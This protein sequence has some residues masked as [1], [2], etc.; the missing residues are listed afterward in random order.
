MIDCASRHEGESIYTAIALVSVGSTLTNMDPVVR[1]VPAESLL[2]GWA[3]RVRAHT[4]LTAHPLNVVARNSGDLTDRLNALP[5]D[6]AGLIAVGT[7]AAHYASISR[8]AWA[9]RQCAVVTDQAMTAVAAAAELLNALI[10]H[11]LPPRQSRVVIAGTATTPLLRRLLMAAGI[12]EVTSWDRRDAVSFPLHLVIRDAEAVIDLLGCPQE[13]AGVV[14]EHPNFIVIGRDDE[15]RLARSLLIILHRMVKEPKPALNI[16]DYYSWALA[17]VA[18]AVSDQP[19]PRATETAVP[20]DGEVAGLHVLGLHANGP[21]LDDLATSRREHPP[22]RHARGGIAW[23]Q[24]ALR[25]TVSRYSVTTNAL[26]AGNRQ[27]R[28][29]STPSLKRER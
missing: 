14:R 24:R 19:A 3:M 16:D 26:V 15:Q 18:A 6:I 29:S 25:A 1:E 21:Q 5:G 27:T 23:K 7:D 8:W 28:D 10:Q 12:S 2:P 13:I 9:N 20:A 4:G 17:I 11:G 22:R